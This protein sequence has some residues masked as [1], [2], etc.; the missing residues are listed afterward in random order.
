MN[1][2]EIVM[3]RHEI[4]RS[5]QGAHLTD[6][7]LQKCNEVYVLL[8]TAALSG[9]LPYKGDLANPDTLM[10]KETD[11]TSYLQSIV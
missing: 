1:R 9:A 4:V 5:E 2:H 11:I 3:T 10:F 7:Q 6:E 8:Y